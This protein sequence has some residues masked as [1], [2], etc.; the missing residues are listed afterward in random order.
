[1]I[2]ILRQSSPIT[3]R[4]DQAD[5]GVYFD[6]DTES[7]GNTDTNQIPEDKTSDAHPSGANPSHKSSPSMASFDDE[8]D[9]ADSPADE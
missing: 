5:E 1:M 7:P 6:A 2:R 4:S 8:T 9:E 3:S